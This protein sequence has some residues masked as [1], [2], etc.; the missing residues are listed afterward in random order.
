[1]KKFRNSDS[2]NSFS[3]LFLM[4][5]F[6]VGFFLGSF[7][8]Y[9]YFNSQLREIKINSIRLG[10]DKLINPLIAVDIPENVGKDEYKDLKKKVE[11]SIE[12]LKNDGKIETASVYFKDSL[13]GDW[14]G[15]NINETYHPASLL[16]VSTLI[17]Y[18]K[19]TET[20][21]NLLNK[22]VLLRLDKDYQEMESIKS[23]KKTFL[24][25]EY[26]IDE[27]IQY[28]IKYS[29][30]NAGI[31]LSSIIDQDF[32]NEVFTDLGLDIPYER[33]TTINPK[34]FA[35][36]FRTL[37][38]STYL[39]RKMSEKALELLS[40]SEFDGGLKSGVSSTTIIAHKFGEYGKL[41]DKG[42]L[43]YRELHDCGMVYA[44]NPYLLCV[45]T[46][47]EDINDMSNGISQ[48]SKIIFNAQEK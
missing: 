17:A 15:I 4:I 43:E 22:K 16:K 33:E 40:S 42:V 2:I 34:S 27:L 20:D 39:N 24:G 8:V 32:L 38:N 25:Q 19:A 26:S 23:S 44:K 3:T 28:M 21:P 11:S 18:Y 41:N 9:I 36:F 12:T 29:D 13:Q 5:I 1:M 35:I 6:F 31:F 30:N 10:E 7:I 14:F 46:R 45:M 47:G 48:I 37:Y